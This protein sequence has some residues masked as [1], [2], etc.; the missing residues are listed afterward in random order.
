MIKLW[1]KHARL[2]TFVEFIK[3]FYM[4]YSDTLIIHK[5]DG[6]MY[7]LCTERVKIAL[8]APKYVMCVF[9]DH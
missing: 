8:V 6:N 7:Y 3:I 4:Y 9:I 2:T 5:M 1:V